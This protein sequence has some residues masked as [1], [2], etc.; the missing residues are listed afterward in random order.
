MIA[1][2]LSDANDFVTSATLD[3]VTYKLHFAYNSYGYWTFDIRNMDN[4][5]L[6]RGVRIVP[7]FPLLHQHRRQKGLPPGELMAIAVNGTKP[8][9][10][11]DFLNGK[12][13]LLY[14]SEDEVNGILQ[15]NV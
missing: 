11:N 7:N 2:T 5:D 12:Y 8:P 1:I 10:R 15:T 4:T 9:G 6:V 14:V 3:G 13:T